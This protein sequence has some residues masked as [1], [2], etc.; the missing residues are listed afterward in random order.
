MLSRIPFLIPLIALI[1]I[2]L[3]IEVGGAIGFWPTVSIF[4]VTGFVGVTMLRRQGFS[5]LSSLQAKMQAGETPAG[6]MLEGVALL[7]GGAMLV[8]PGFLTDFMGFLL[9]TPLTRKLL[10]GRIGGALL[11][12]G[13]VVSRSYSQTTYSSTSE[14]DGPFR[15]D[16]SGGPRQGAGGDKV[17]EGEYTRED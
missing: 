17:I 16:P 15:G 6:E 8:T 3:I 7:I 11:R 14:R 1:E 10:I 5:L 9:L 12:S 13:R 2:Y 4:I